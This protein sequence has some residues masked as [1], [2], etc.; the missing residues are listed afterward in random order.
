[1]GWRR[2]IGCLTLQVIS[3]KRAINY[4]A[5]LRKMTYKDKASYGSPPPYIWHIWCEIFFFVK[6]LRICMYTYTEAFS[7]I[8]VWT[9]IDMQICSK[10]YNIWHRSSAIIPDFLHVCVPYVPGVC[11]MQLIKSLFRSHF[12]TRLASRT[13]SF[14][15]AFV[16]FF[17]CSWFCSYTQCSNERCGA[18]VEYHFQAFNEPYAPS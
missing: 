6:C 9:Y 16:G 15:Y 3:H 18:G 1:M 12:D 13:D 8:N 17:I 2:P 4:T 11:N 5:L 10:F 14:L 7:R